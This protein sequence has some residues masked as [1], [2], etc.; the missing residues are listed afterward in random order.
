MWPAYAV[1]V[2]LRII[3]KAVNSR[4]RFPPQGLIPCWPLFLVIM[5][6]CVSSSIAMPPIP[7]GL[8]KGLIAEDVSG[9]YQGMYAV[10]CCVRNR[11]DAGMNHGLCG[12][13][14]KDLDAFV[15]RQPKKYH[16]MA[17]RIV[18]QVFEQNAPDNTG[19]ATHYEAIERYGLPYWTKNMIKTVRI[20]EHTFFKERR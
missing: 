17:K 16:A 11:L 12:L 2:V 6:L 9:G 13:K 18:I 7:N 4:K 8:W 10:A 5:L 1:R 20:G 3:Q 15:N 19:G 14:R